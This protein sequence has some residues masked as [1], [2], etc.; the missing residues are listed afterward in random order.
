M[1]HL[2]FGTNRFFPRPSMLPKHGHLPSG[3]L[4]ALDRGALGVKREHVG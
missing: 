2:S 3:N 1:V 4:V